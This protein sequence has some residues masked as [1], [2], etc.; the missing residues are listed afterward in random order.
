MEPMKAVRTD[1][2]L[3]VWASNVIFSATFLSPR[4]P[5]PLY[6]FRRQP[7]TFHRFSTTLSH[8]PTPGPADLLMGRN[9]G[10][11]AVGR[12]VDPHQVRRVRVTHLS[13][14]LGYLSNCSH[15]DSMH[16]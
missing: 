7:L 14:A 5:R 9:M 13:S 15:P 3:L 6:Q 8:P 10:F 11:L 12:R 1:D 4:R 16:Q 2:C